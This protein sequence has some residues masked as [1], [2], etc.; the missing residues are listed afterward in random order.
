M[1]VP[2][3][4]ISWFCTKL[5]TPVPPRETDNI[6][7]DILAAF[8]AVTLAPEPDKFTAVIFVVDKILLILFHVKFSDWIRAFS[9]LPIIKRFATN[10]PEPVPPLD[11]GKIPVVCEDKLIKLFKVFCPVPPLSIDNIPLDILFAFK[12]VIL[13]PFPEI[14]AAFRVSFIHVK[15]ALWI[16]EPKSLPTI[17]WLAVKIS[18][19]VPPLEDGKTPFVC[20][21]KFIK[22]LRVFVPVPPLVVGKIP[23][24]WEDKLIK[25]SSV[26]EPVPPLDIGKMLTIFGKL[27]LRY[28]LLFSSTSIPPSSL[29]FKFKALASLTIPV[30]PFICPALENWVKFIGSVSNVKKLDVLN[31][32][33]ELLLILPFLTNTKVPSLILFVLLKSLLL[34]HEEDDTIYIPF[35]YLLFWFFTK[36]LLFAEENTP[37]I[38]NRPDI[39]L[40]FAVVA[41]STGSI[42]VR[43]EET[44]SKSFLVAYPVKSIDWLPLI[45]PL[46]SILIVILSGFITP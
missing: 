9:P 1:F 22:L 26:L 32:N 7:V 44:V 8:K 19:P 34:F 20:E 40:I 12:K 30:P 11:T 43:P 38:C 42:K 37:S 10:I 46:L 13:L 15:P 21:D 33:P 25:L 45:I 36:I 5:L 41:K 31:T 23:F 18:L 4:T 3:P 2:L 39:G 6:P 27:K 29:I 14:L 24:V 35:S 16:T 28:I 17:N